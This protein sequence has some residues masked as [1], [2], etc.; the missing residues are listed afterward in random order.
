MST[1]PILGSTGE[2]TARLLLSLL[3]VNVRSAKTPYDH[4]KL[5][6][7]SFNL[8]PEVELPELCHKLHTAE[9]ADAREVRPESIYERQKHFAYQWLRVKQFRRLLAGLPPLDRA[10]T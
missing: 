5:G 10:H 6:Y 7:A 4:A 3:A 9:R 1:D 2:C 8:V